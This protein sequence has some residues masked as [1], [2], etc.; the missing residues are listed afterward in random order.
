[1][2]SFEQWFNRYKYY[3]VVH[4]E[5]NGISWEIP[6][7]LH[8]NRFRYISWIYGNSSEDCF[9]GYTTEIQL[10][11]GVVPIACNENFILDLLEVLND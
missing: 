7:A 5:W 9:L 8:K 11:S 1:M 10:N 2:T 3:K 6:L 4:P